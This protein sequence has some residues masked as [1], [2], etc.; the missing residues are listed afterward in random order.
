MKLLGIQNAE[1]I[2]QEEFPTIYAIT[3]TYTRLTQKADL[4]RLSQTFLH[5]PKFR[6]IVVEDSNEKTGLVARFLSNCGV[7]YTHLATKT[8]Q[9]L[10]RKGDDPRWLKARGVDQRN[11]GLQWVREHYDK[12]RQRGVV[13]FADDDN[14]YDVQIFKQV[15]WWGAIWYFLSFTRQIILCSCLVSSTLSSLWWCFW[16]EQHGVLFMWMWHCLWSRVIFTKRHMSWLMI[17]LQKKKIMR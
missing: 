5:I 14:T 12:T 6:W 11:L 4:T 1:E 8:R 3:P 9:N 10:Q 7:T 16:S 2:Y 17:L 13:Y 15:R